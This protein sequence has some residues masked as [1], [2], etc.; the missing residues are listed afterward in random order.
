MEMMVSRQ[1]RWQRQHVEAG[2]CRSCS[3]PAV[4]AGFCAKHYHGKVGPPRPPRQPGAPRL[5]PDPRV[6]R[7]SEILAAAPRPKTLTEVALEFGVSVSRV[8][9][10]VHGSEDTERTRAIRRAYR[11]NDIH[12]TVMRELEVDRSTAYRLVHAARRRRPV[13]TLTKST[14]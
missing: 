7:V 4:R 2:L 13:K 8:F 5:V 3:R 6:T 11:P 14:V 12:D 1:L 9:T 10:I